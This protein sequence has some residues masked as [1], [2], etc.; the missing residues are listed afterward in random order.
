MTE[1]LVDAAQCGTSDSGITAGRVRAPIN[2]G[3]SSARGYS[4]LQYGGGL[5]RRHL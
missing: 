1:C 5:L 3:K 4:G 2:P